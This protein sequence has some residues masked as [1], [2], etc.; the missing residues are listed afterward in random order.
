[1][2]HLVDLRKKPYSL[3]EEAI[4]WIEENIAQMTLDEKI[5]HLF[6]NMGSQRTEEYLT[7][8][9]NDYKIAAVRYN[10]GPAA[11]IW[12]QN[13]ILQTKSKIPLLIAANTESGGNGAV[14]DGT[15]IGDEIKI[16]A[17]TD[18]HYA[19]EMGKVAGL[20]AAAVGCNASFAPIMDLSRNWRNPII[21]N[22]TWGANVDQVIELSK[23]Y[24]RGIMEHG[25]VP[26][27]KHFPGDGIDERDHHLSFASNPMTKS[28]W[29]E[30]FGRIYCEMA[31]A[32]LPGIMAG[33][34]HLPN[35]EKEM[36]PERELDD[37]LPA[38]L[39]KTLL[40]ELL[41]GE[42]GYNG[43]I[44]T[45]AS[46]MI[47]MTA[48]M[49]RRELLPTAIEAGCDL[50]LFFN[51]PEE[52][53]RW[54]KEGLENG[55]LSEERLHDALRRTLGLKAKLGLHQF[56]G[57][58]Q[59]IMLPKEEALA[60]IGRDEAKQLAKEVADKAIT[61][62]K[63]KQEGIF[64]VKPERYKRI[65]LVEVD[66]YKG[67]F[68]AMINAGKKRAADTLKELLEA[69]GHQ[70]S[71]WEN[72][73][74]RIAKLPEEERPAAIANVYASKRP[75]AEITDNYDLIIN[76]VDVNSG[77]TTQR[78]IWPAAKGTPDQPFYVHEIPTIV[79]SVQHPFA[80]ADMPQ[81]ATYINAYDGLPVTLEALV[82]KLAGE[83]DFTGVS[84][85]DAYCGLL[86]TRI[87]RGK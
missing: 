63:A 64:P 56:E 19:Y 75:I 9:L 57:R 43:A 71:I 53:L 62:V 70:V 16:A 82:A 73:E 36:H 34:I 85:V 14:T 8:V 41:R 45:D 78:I 12:E 59:E 58:R 39:N 49:P 65:L 2:T 17:T 84:P 1:M 30:T 20:E 38:S 69:R 76:L 23:E 72:T 81:V 6:V 33:H 26:F 32:G 7:G 55:L 66:G 4:S 28:E 11:D 40:D 42:L 79:V 86:D 37:M 47:G 68:G 61:L 22:R 18:P 48:S 25:I 80:L 51:D 46:H 21:A 54:M 83:S 10:P 24:M 44:V 35:V 52:D 60:L 3:D 13:Y 31:E 67:G 27:A 87:W 50:F 74:A 5:G 15:K 77:G 29:M